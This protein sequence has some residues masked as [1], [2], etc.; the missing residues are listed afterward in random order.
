MPR[1]P[2]SLSQESEVEHVFSLLGLQFV[3]LSFSLIALALGLFFVF[4][5]PEPHGQLIGLLIWAA[6]VPL[7]LLLDKLKLGCRQVPLF[8]HP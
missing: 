5:G 6:L 8:N 4:L 1:V 3:Q 2:D 7:N